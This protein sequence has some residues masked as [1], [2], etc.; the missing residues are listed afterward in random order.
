MEK[1]MTK[2]HQQQKEITSDKVEKIESL[3]S[4]MADREMFERQDKPMLK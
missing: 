1:G 2:D 4:R 3:L